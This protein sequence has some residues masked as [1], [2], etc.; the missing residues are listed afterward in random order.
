MEI[1]F[2]QVAPREHSANE[3]NYN[4]SQG[5]WVYFAN[6][7]RLLSYS[8]L[9]SHHLLLHIPFL[10]IDIFSRASTYMPLQKDGGETK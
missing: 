5:F 7:L 8:E 2:I 6:P 3:A 9:N 4:F 10:I 1:V